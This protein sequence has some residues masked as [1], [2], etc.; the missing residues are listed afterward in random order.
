M[1]LTHAWHTRCLFR[2]FAVFREAFCLLASAKAFMFAC[3]QWYVTGSLRESDQIGGPDFGLAIKEA[4][5]V[6]D[7]AES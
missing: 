4:S 6:D 3:M 5:M 2:A 1:H 7:Q